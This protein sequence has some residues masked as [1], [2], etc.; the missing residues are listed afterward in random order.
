MSNITGLKN[1]KTNLNTKGKQLGKDF[2][3]TLVNRTRVLSQQMQKDLNN[4]VDRGAVPFTQNAILFIFKNNKTGVKCSILIK[5]IQ[6]KYLY[7]IIV[8]QNTFEKFIPT[9]AA[10][11]TKQGNITGLRSNLQKGRYKIVKQRGKERLIDTKAKKRNKRV[12]GV[13]E[14]KRRKIIYDFYNEAEQGARLVIS[15]IKGS[16]R[17]TKQ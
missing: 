6:A 9:S 15:D 10:R 13:K 16:F 14:Q 5:D 8:K 7:D 4:S 17:I 1:A 12:I 3:K 2:Q 11:L